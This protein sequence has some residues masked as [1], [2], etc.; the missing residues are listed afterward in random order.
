M[1]DPNPKKIYGDKKIK[2]Q[3]VPPAASIAIARGLAEG[4]EKYSPWNWRDDDIETLTYIGAI[5][6][7]LA[8]YLE[9]ED[10]DPDSTTGKSHLD[11][12]IASLAILIDAESVGSL[13]DNRPKRKAV[14]VLKALT[15]GSVEQRGTGFKVGDIRH[16][17]AD[18]DGND[19]GLSLPLAVA[20]PF[21]E[22]KPDAF[23]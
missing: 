7:H 23:T 1:A 5:Q 12:A 2:L 20:L 9:G 11:G 13:I 17:L 4:A 22:A 18:E 16:R 8:A 3:L 10:L 15:Q 19:T 14:G 21:T 6:R